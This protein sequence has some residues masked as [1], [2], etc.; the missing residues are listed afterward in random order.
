MTFH[1]FTCED[2]SEIFEEEIDAY[3]AQT[4]PRNT[5]SHQERNGYFA[6][7]V[8]PVNTGLPHQSNPSKL[9]ESSDNLATQEWGVVCAVHS[10]TT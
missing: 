1:A 7:D 2:S 3:A 5:P 8:Q 4:F 6:R 10:A 9:I